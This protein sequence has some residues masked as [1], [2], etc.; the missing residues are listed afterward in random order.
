M[1]VQLQSLDLADNC[2]TA[3]GVLSSLP[4]LRALNLSGN[5]I[6]RLDDQFDPSVLLSDRFCGMF[7]SYNIMI[8]NIVFSYA[9]HP[10]SCPDESFLMNFKI[11]DNNGTYFGLL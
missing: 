6:Q 8:A 4:S 7:S 10:P 11:V 5:R 3:F 2:L 1:F 9:I